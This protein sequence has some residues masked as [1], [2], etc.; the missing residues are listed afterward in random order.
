M[1]SCGAGNEEIVFKDKFRNRCSKSLKDMCFKNTKECASHELLDQIYDAVCSLRKMQ[2]ASVDVIRGCCAY[3]DFTSR[4]H[5][6]EHKVKVAHSTSVATEI[7]NLLDSATMRSMPDGGACTKEDC[8]LFHLK[9]LNPELYKKLHPTRGPLHPLFE[10][11]IAILLTDLNPFFPSQP[12]HHRT[13]V[14]ATLQFIEACQLEYEYSESGFE[15][16]ADTPRLPLFLRH[17]SGIPE[18][19]VLFVL[20][21]S[22]QVPENYASEDGSSDRLFF[23]NKIYPMLPELTAVSDHVNDVLSFYKEY[24]EEYVGANYIFT[25]AKAENITLFEVLDGL[26]NQIVEIRKN[27]MAIA[28]RTNSL[29]VKRTVAQYFQ[30]YIAF[31]FSWEK[32]YRLGEVFGDGWFQGNLI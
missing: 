2:S 23:Y 16:Q 27:V 22:H 15:I 13:L 6:F 28:E 21:G 18:P 11:M 20:V 4:H 17:K 25:V 24:E 31:H 9:L 29:E 32:R 14:A 30:G 8:E 12:R 19:F 3:A 10:E 1:A 26:M 7:D 5:T